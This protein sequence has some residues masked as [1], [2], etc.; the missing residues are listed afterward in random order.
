MTTH[1]TI[2]RPYAKATFEQALVHAQLK[3]WHSILFVLA[4]AVENKT[5][6]KTIS[7]PSFPASQKFRWLSDICKGA[8]PDLDR[9]L[10]N[11][12]DDFIKLLLAYKRLFILPDVLNAYQ[13][14]LYQHEKILIVCISSAFSLSAS[15]KNRLD[16]VLKKYFNT[17]VE[18][19]YKVDRSL[20]GGLVI[21]AENLLIDASIK[22]QLKRL[23]Y[24]L[25]Q[26]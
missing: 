15:H 25:I 16:I 18:V 22:N 3:Q 19:H 2:A 12:V 17:A 21:Q 6:S 5:F 13:Q 8:L 7:N 23:K 11:N 1:R 10:R 14:L 4:K 9:A 26:R 20:I 24:H